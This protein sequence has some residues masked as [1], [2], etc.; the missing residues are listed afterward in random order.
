MAQCDRDA[1]HAEVERLLAECG[2]RDWGEGIESFLDSGGTS[3]G[4]YTREYQFNINLILSNRQSK[5][6]VQYVIIQF[7]EIHISFW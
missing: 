2:G 7:D 3:N 4:I 6:N 1:D 5:G